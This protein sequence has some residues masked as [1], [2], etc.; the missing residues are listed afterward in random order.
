MN[1]ANG[2]MQLGI[3]YTLSPTLFLSGQPILYSSPLV[4]T[5]LPS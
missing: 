3:T 1:M 5:H 4:N 2:G